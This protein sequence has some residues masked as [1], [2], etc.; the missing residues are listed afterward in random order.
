MPI[1]IS[2]RGTHSPISKISQF[3][4]VTA[5]AISRLRLTLGHGILTPV[6]EISSPLKNLS[7]FFASILMS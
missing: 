4:E 7:V 2:G 6:G 1:K 5:M 3:R